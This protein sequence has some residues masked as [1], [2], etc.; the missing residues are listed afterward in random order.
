MILLT[1]DTSHRQSELAWLKRLLPYREPDAR[2]A[3]FEL[4]VT[5]VPLLALWALSWAA[6]AHGCWWGLVLT[7]PAAGF[8]LRL[9]MIQHDCGHG[10]FFGRRSIDDWLGRAIGVLTLTPYDCW[11]RTHAVHHASAAI[12]T[13]AASAISRR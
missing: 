7:L 2:R 5:V 3:F 4:A 12:S 6:M 1:T 10:A 8:L 9:F 13:R 11:R